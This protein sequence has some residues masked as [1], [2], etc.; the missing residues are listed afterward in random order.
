MY[1]VAYW[2]SNHCVLL[3]WP[4]TIWSKC[5]VM[6]K[7]AYWTSNH[8]ALPIW[9]PVEVLLLLSFKCTNWLNNNVI[10]ICRICVDG[11]YGSPCMVIYIQV[12]FL[13][14]LNPLTPSRLNLFPYS[15]NTVC[16]IRP[17][18]WIVLST[19]RNA[20]W[21]KPVYSY[22]DWSYSICGSFQ[23]SKVTTARQ[24]KLEKN[25]H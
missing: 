11:P 4:Q 9:P 14:C 18:N 23:W 12:S 7:V 20:V 17:F 15:Y 21:S 16:K 25:N 6:Y 13:V 2:T 3:K 8:C 5:T 22:W 24:L 1:K 10:L 19:G